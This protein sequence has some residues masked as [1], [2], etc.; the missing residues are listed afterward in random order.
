MIFMQGLSSA[1]PDNNT[2]LKKV[3]TEEVSKVL[4][5]RFKCGSKVQVI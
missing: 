5:V 3:D 1:M 2:L 4:K